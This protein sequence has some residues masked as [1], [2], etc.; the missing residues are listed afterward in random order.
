MEINGNIQTPTQSLN[1][2]VSQ[3]LQLRMGQ[4][5]RATVIQ[6]LSNQIALLKIGK[7]EVQAESPKPL[8]IGTV[9][10]LEVTT[11]PQTAGEKPILKVLQL[12][13][14]DNSVEQTTTPNKLSPSTQQQTQSPQTQP[15]ISQEIR[16]AVPMQTGLLP[17]L[18]NLALLQQSRTSNIVL[19]TL[20]Q[21]LTKELLDK[22]PTRESVQTSAGLKKAIENSGI[23]FE[24]K[25]LK[26]LN[27]LP[28]NSKLPVN[29]IEAIKQILT[30][31]QLPTKQAQ[32]I[33]L[34]DT[35]SKNG[36]QRATTLS[37][38]IKGLMFKLL[39]IIPKAPK[40]TPSETT[41]KSATTPQ[42]QTTLPIM[43]PPSP[44]MQGKQPQPQK[45]QAPTLADITNLQTL[46]QELGRQ[47]EGNIAR[48][49]LHQIASLPTPDN[50]VQ[51]WSFELPIRTGDT[52]D[53]FS[54]VIEEREHS[55]KD[56]SQS[57][58]QWSV[59]IAVELGELGPMHVRLR[60][61]NDQ[62]ATTIW[63]DKAETAQLVNQHLSEL[64]QKYTQAG[65]EYS[66]LHCLN[67]TPTDKAAQTQPTVM[68]DINV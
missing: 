66:E 15:A 42:Q 9:L 57:S 50:N 22:L 4:I 18:S 6:Q 60:L 44:P 68:L 37:N 65:I 48:T 29:N 3:T 55:E 47:T 41:P 23:L 40:E 12:V 21:T 19:P 27:T 1:S 2:L 53:L 7:H 30:K 58:K 61:L 51:A 62:I 14:S 32:D 56:Q 49:Q 16:R 17:L 10:K 33:L 46:F 28:K 39:A 45:A 54:M 38:D 26:T 36:E 34:A 59:M 67:G 31:I 13:L 35:T 20:I 8:A 24:N 25:L 11:L 5:L 64:K 43:P 63:A 52:I